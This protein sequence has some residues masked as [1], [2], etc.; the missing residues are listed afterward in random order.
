MQLIVL[1]HAEAEPGGDQDANRA[2][3]RRGVLQAESMG[4]Q[5]AQSFDQ[6]QVV[7]S[8]WL[9]AAET[10]RIIAASTGSDVGHLDRLLPSGDP[11]S[12]A[13]AL[14]PLWCDDGALLVVTHQPLCGRLINW[15]AEGVAG[16]APVAPCSGA[17]LSLE[18][19]AAGMARF[20][21]WL[22]ADLSPC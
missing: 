13:L 7:A 8:P 12:V 1:R 15:L 5:L 20:P 17:Q 6:L 14:E 2:L 10:A 4:R 9:R 18:W 11:A 3:T 16:P 22:S 21:R 19:P